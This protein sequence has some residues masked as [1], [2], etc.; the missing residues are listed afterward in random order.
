MLRTRLWM[1]SVLI[2]LTVGMLMFDQGLAPWHPFQF[3]F[4]SLLVLAA[5]W[6]IVRLFGPERPVHVPLLFLGSGLLTV[7]N[8]VIP[9]LWGPDAV[10]LPL[11]GG[12][13]AVQLA[14]F[15]AEMALFR[16]PGQSVERMARTCWGV[17]YLALLPSFLA[18]LPWLYPPGSAY[19]TT[20]LAL[21][22]FVPKACDVGAYFAGRLF[23]KHRMTPTLSP[24]KTW[25]GA[26][27]G[28]ILA[29]IVAIAIDRLSA[30][31]VLGGRYGWEIG[32]GMILGATGMLGDLAESLIKRDCRK[33]DA[34]ESVPGFGGVLDVVDA[35]V[36]A[37]PVAWLGCWLSRNWHPLP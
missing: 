18:Q 7:A 8:F 10:W 31:P 33:K 16:D 37:A 5:A 22:I 17:G 29:A 6:E 36:F 12:F 27:G 13:V 9:A 23:G 3:A 15:L 20:A 25:E 21:A 35:V 11:F 26:G 19:G 28:L 30:A 1:G 14:A 4:Q 34:S 2:A 24:K 32:F